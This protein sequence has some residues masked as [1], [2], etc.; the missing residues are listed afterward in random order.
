MVT[1]AGQ[2]SNEE[3]SAFLAQYSALIRAKR[4]PYVIA[5]DLRRSSDMPAAQRKIITDYMQK[6][7][8]FA[9]L[10]CR[11][12]V[13]VFSSALMRALLTGILWVRKPATPL[14]VA[15]TLDEASEWAEKQIAS[16]EHKPNAASL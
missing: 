1:P 9:R 12:T 6:Q 5:I 8:E 2:I 7:E 15:A 13:L 4:A 14:H 3:L 10:Y 16:S 11:G